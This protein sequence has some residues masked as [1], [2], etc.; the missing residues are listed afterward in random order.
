MAHANF[1]QVKEEMKDLEAKVDADFNNNSLLKLPFC[2]LYN[3]MCEIATRVLLDEKQLPFS[4]LSPYCYIFEKELDFTPLSPE[5]SKKLSYEISLGDFR[6][7]MECANLNIVFPFIHSRLYTLIRTSE[8]ESHLDYASEEIADLEI[9][10]VVITNLSI[11]RISRLNSVEDRDFFISALRR[12]KKNEPINVTKCRNRISKLYSSI[13]HSFIEEP[14]VPES[15]YTHIGFST[16]S[17]FSE[18]RHAF[19][20]LSQT[21]IDAAWLV[22][23]Y[24]KENALYNSQT[25][26]LLCTGLAMAC[27]DSAVLRDLILNICRCN[28]GDYEKFCEFFFSGPDKNKNLSNTFMPPFWQINDKVYF[29]PGAV[30]TLLGTRNLL[31]SIQNNPEKNTQYKFDAMISDLFEP[32]LLS[33]AEKYFM[34]KGLST[35]VGKI[36]KGGEIDMLVYCKDSHTVLTIQAKATLFPENARMVRRLDDRINEGIKQTSKF[37]ALHDSEKAILY[38]SCFGEDIN[39]AQVNHIR[40]VLTNSS[41]GSYKSWHNLEKQKI[42]PLNCNLL[43]NSLPSCK[44]L[45]ELPEAIKRFIQHIVTTAKPEIRDKIFHLKGHTIHQKHIEADG[46]ETLFKNGLA[47]G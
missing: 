40:G 16:P 1:V 6:S 7:L 14:L 31:I 25:E 3:H 39:F 2:V 23:S 32:A 10:D 41:F 13:S 45:D 20:A 5:E 22:D 18:I 21:Y 19:C 24:L 35:A 46:V 12:I 9:R 33:R 15:F 43:R 11:P 38:K 26:K 29:M 44:T 28:I 8:N 37:D 47:G 4:V 36:F 34:E 30:P 17:A 27:L 42:I